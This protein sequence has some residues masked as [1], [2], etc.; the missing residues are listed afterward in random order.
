MLQRLFPFLA[1]LSLLLLPT[2][3]KLRAQEWKAEAEAA[4]QTHRMA[5]IS[6]TVLDGGNTVTDAQVRIRLRKHAFRWGTIADVPA[7]QGLAAGGIPIGGTHPYWNHFQLFN[8]VGFGNAGKWRQWL[9]AGSR[10]TYL[11]SMDW[12]NTQNI[13]N[14][15]HA[16]IWP[17]I[18]RWNAVP[19]TVLNVMAEGTRSREQ[20]IRDIIHEHLQTYLPVMAQKRVY[21]VDLINELV[22]EAD[23]SRDLLGL[24]D[25]ADRIREH[26]QWYQWAKEA[27]PA[28]G[29]VANEYDLYQNGNDFHEDFVSYVSAMIDLG[30]PIDGVGMQGH[31]FSTAPPYSELKRRLAEVAVLGLPMAVTEFD[32]VSNTYE[33]MERVL[34]SVFSEPLCNNFTVWGAWDG[35]QWRDNGPV[36]NLDWSLKPSGQAFIDL[37]HKRWRTDTLLA[38]DAANIDYA[39]KGDYDVYVEHDGQVYASEVKLTDDGLALTVDVATADGYALPDAALVIEGAPDTVYPDQPFRLTI[40]SQADIEHVTYYDGDLVLGR[41]DS[42]PFGLLQVRTSARE[43]VRPGAEVVFKSGYR[44]RLVGTPF[45][46]SDANEAPVFGDI[47]PASGTTLFDEAAPRVSVVVQDADGDALRVALLDQDGNVLTQ[48]ATPPYTLSLDGLDPGPHRLRLRA[49]DSRFGSTTREYL[50]NNVRRGVPISASDSP[51]LANDDVEERTDQAVDTDGGLDLGERLTGIHFSFPGIPAGAIIDS[52]FVQFTSQ[53]SDQAGPMDVEIFGELAAPSQ[54]LTGQNGNLTSRGFTQARTPWGGV[55]NWLSLNERG[56]KQRTPDI[57]S[58]IREI[59]SQ[60]DWTAAQPLNLL[61]S[62]GTQSKRSAYSVDQSFP[63]RPVLTVHYQLP[64]VAERPICADTAEVLFVENGLALEDLGKSYDPDAAGTVPAYLRFSIADGGGTTSVRRQDRA[65]LKWKSQGYYQRNRELGQIINIPEGDSIRLDAIVLRT[66]NTQSAV[67]AGAPGAEVYLQLYSVEGTATIND[68]GT[69]TGTPSE[70]GFSDN[71]RTDDYL[72][73]IAYRPIAI[74]RGGVFP[75]I[76]ATTGNGGEAGHLR[77]L[78]WDLLEGGE[79]VLEGGRRYAFL[80]GFTASGPGKGF[81]L[82]NNNLAG[83]AEAP[84]LRTDANG[85]DWWSMRREGDGTLPPTRV[86][87][88]NPPGGDSLRMAL[89]DESLYAFNHECGLAPTTDGFP[90]V[91]TYRTLEF[92]VE[93][94]EIGTPTRNVQRRVAPLK[95]YPNPDMG[96][97]TVDFKHDAKNDDAATLELYAPDGKMASQRPVQVLRGRNQINVNRQVHPGTYLLR[98]ITKDGIYQ[99]RTIVK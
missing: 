58:V 59:I 95:I 67:L 39:A 47:F 57:A 13:S 35:Q 4:I 18:R 51:Q 11:Q 44:T 63:N 82:A 53:K 43:A 20:V 90:D 3:N 92:Y 71:H 81:S 42:L 23:L 98:I 79:L 60:P 28:V 93:T 6:V 1:L 52:A 64:N 21:E 89:Q 65:N 66:G 34:Y 69:P 83:S 80:V 30:A 88:P 22:H 5:P 26:T 70:H 85:A 36:F 78:R 86:P 8:S 38:S 87:G 24:S 16:P 96:S 31:F 55:P 10:A 74:L 72:D 7:I 45:T 75:D 29:L 40:D 9:Q 84:E 56:P 50:V 27:A 32:M 17:S 76:P 37:V 99:G 49:E 25:R 77:Y 62:S 2:E 15:G 14:R 61:I 46:I 48:S 54:P 97:L 41:K 91:D 12:F 94:K 19:D 68:N 33:E 73:G